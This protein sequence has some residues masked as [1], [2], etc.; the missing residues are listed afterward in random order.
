MP[1]HCCNTLILSASTL[2][3]II[4]KYIRKDEQE[5][6]IFDFER[7]VPIGDVPDW[8]EQ[9]IEKWGTKWV[10][11]DVSVGEDRID[12]FTA[13]TPPIPILKKL[14]ELHQELAFRLDYCEPSM[15]F[16]GTA[17]AK[18]QNGEVLL[19]D[20]CREMIEEEPQKTENTPQISY[21]TLFD[22]WADFDDANAPSEMTQLIETYGMGPVDAVS[23]AAFCYGHKRAL[24][25]MGEAG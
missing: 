4:A 9:R 15:A 11:Y 14:A 10:G 13:W 19:R 18:W 12:F 5:G 3:A 23:F 17:T 1:N 24:K 20:D 25:K 2:P 8:R 7:I 16:Q 21:E 6:R 22:I